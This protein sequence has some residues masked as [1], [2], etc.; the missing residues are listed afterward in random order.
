M[1]T[2]APLLRDFRRTLPSTRATGVAPTGVPGVTFFWID[3]PVP[4]APLLY[5]AGI[6]VVGQGHKVG[7][8]GDRRFRYDADTCLVLGVPVPF[9]CE[10]HASSAEPLLGVRIDVDLTTLHGLVARLSGELG[11]ERTA[12][13]AALSGVE[14]VR[15][16]GALLAATTRLLESLRDPM[17]RT[18]VGPAAVEEVLYRVLRGPQG[19]VL[20]ALTRHHTPYSNVARALERM[21]RDYRESLSVEELAQVSAM[22]VS[23]FHRAFKSVTGESPLQYLKKLRLLTAKGL[24]VLEGR[25]VDETAFEVGYASPAQFSRDFKR[26]FRVPPSEAHRLPY[27]DAA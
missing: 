24:L 3:E 6:V 23:S 7:Y 9:E 1:S 5:S 26:Y 13:G 22:G 8:L 20:A 12:S 2:L 14:P 19:N 18:V 15:M 11:L 17:D 16:E 25:R 21:H 27:S 10:S 4:R